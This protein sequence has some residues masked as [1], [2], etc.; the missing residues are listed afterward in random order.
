MPSLHNSKVGRWIRIISRRLADWLGVDGYDIGGPR[1]G[2][3]DVEIR[4]RDQPLSV[5]GIANSEYT[6]ESAYDM[7]S[8]GMGDAGI[9]CFQVLR[10]H[11]V[12]RFSGRW[13]R[14]WSSDSSGQGENWD[15]W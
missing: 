13:E 11:L 14:R 12:G 6:G 3:G 15:W 4:H 7:L 2:L 10:K 5:D 1:S 9:D 8:Y